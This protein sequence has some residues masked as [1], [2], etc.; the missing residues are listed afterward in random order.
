M[1]D[2]PRGFRPDFTCPAVLR[3]LHGRLLT[4]TYGAITLSRSASQLIL[5]N[6]NFVT[7]QCQ[8]YNPKVQALWFGLYR[9]RSPLLTV[10]IFLSIPVANEMF[11]FTTSTFNLTIYSLGDNLHNKL[12]SPIRKSPDH[13]LLTTPRSIS[14]LVTSFIG[15]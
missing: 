8:S 10:S 7:P 11:Q 3:I 4:F 14:Q 1:R 12:G 6:V 13:S 9:F 15:S 5:L 2:G